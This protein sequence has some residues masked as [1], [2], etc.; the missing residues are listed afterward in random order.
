M[1]FRVLFRLI[2]TKSYFHHYFHLLGAKISPYEDDYSRFLIHILNLL[3]FKPLCE[4]IKF[5]SFCLNMVLFIFSI[6][7]KANNIVLRFIFIKL[8]MNLIFFYVLFDFTLTYLVIEF[9]FMFVSTYVFSLKNVIKS[10]IRETKELSYDLFGYPEGYGSFA[11][12]IYPD[13]YQDYL[14]SFDNPQ[15]PNLNVYYPMRFALSSIMIRLTGVILSI[16]FLFILIFNFTNLFIIIDANIS[17]LRRSIDYKYFEYYYNHRLWYMKHFILPKED[18]L[19]FYLTLKY[20]FIIIYTT[21]KIC[22]NYLFFDIYFSLGLTEIFKIKYLI[23]NFFYSFFVYIF[24]IVLPIHFYYV[25]YHS[26]KIIYISKYIGYI[27]FYLKEIIKFFLRLLIVGLKKIWGIIYLIA[28]V[29][30][31]DVHAQK[32]KNE[33]KKIN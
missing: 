7:I 16:A 15:A 19:T 13:E 27:F 20:L 3:I 33:V 32:N 29:E 30:E 5:I 31:P 26:Y 10:F 11:M 14:D 6:L 4:I 1:L 12:E 17:E 28:T 23:L 25:V 18:I 8:P 22:F 2:E 21:I 9:A 24:I